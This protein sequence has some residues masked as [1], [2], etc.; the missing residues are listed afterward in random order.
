MWQEQ[1]QN[2]LSGDEGLRLAPVC[3]DSSLPSPSTLILWKYKKFWL[4]TGQLYLW[5][6]LTQLPWLVAP[7]SHFLIQWFGRESKDLLYWSQ[8][9]CALSVCLRVNFFWK[10]ASN[11]N[12]LLWILIFEITSFIGS[13][14]FLWLKSFPFVHNLHFQN[15]HVNCIQHLNSPQKMDLQATWYLV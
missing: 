2:T 7:W 14:F 1:E 3:F 10:T 5:S 9:K 12:M 13:E 6:F 11:V 8:S 15:F 4:K